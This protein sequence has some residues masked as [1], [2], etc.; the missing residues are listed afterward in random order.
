MPTLALRHTASLAALLS[1]TALGSARAQSSAAPGTLVQQDSSKVR[2]YRGSFSTGFEMSWFQPCD[3]P[4]GDRLWWVTLTEDARLQRDSLVKLLPHRPTN[5]LLVRWRGTVSPV[6]RSGVGHM[7][8]GSRYMLVTSIIS[9][10]A[11]TDAGACGP[12]TVS[13]LPHAP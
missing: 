8:R 1:I 3:A 13:A 7:G 11:L 4:A 12:T 10:Q 9:V 6:M 5:G 2:E